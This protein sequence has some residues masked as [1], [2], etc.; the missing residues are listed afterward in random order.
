MPTTSASGIVLCSNQNTCQN[1]GVC[2]LVNGLTRCVCPQGNKFI[3][4]NDFL[5]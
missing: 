4:I 5:G 1:Q 3:S 2:Y